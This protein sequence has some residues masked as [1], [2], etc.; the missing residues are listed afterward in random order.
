MPERHLDFHPPVIAHRGAR[1]RAP[2]N[3]LAAFEAARA[4]GVLWIETDVKL[5]SDGVPILM[6]DE[7][8][9][10]TTNMRGLVADTMW[11]DMQTC[12]AGGWF[13][14]SFAGE[15]I[16]TLA[17]A[18]A[19]S[20]A[21]GMRFNF[22]LKPCPGR[23][24][25]TAMVALIEAA[26]LWPESAPPPL[27]SSFDIEALTIAAQLHPGWPRGL[28]LEEWRDDWREIATRTNATSLHLNA[29]SLTPERLVTLRETHV[30]TLAYTV[31][32]PARARD[33][34]NAGVCA[35]FTDNPAEIL[36]AI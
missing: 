36:K 23:A 5:T 32:D 13:N 4:D 6:H 8:L 2:E 25:A 9:D 28:L 27:I 7:T 29:E 30:S 18:L 33:L 24:R 15:R 26:K 22:E 11:A 17:D 14:A 31:N 19:F 16:P 3:T 35:V 1:N 12:D 34:L 10:R 20:R 21:T